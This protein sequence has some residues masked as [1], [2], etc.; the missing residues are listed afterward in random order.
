ML[1]GEGV[2][3]GGGIKGRKNWDNCDS[4]I[5]KIYFKKKKMKMGVKSSIECLRPI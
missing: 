1:V 4:I 2:Q 3:G 5:D